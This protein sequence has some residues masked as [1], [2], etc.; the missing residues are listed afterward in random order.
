[1]ESD[2][3][4]AFDARVAPHLEDIRRYL[5]RRTQSLGPGVADGDDLLIEVLATA[6]RRLD[7]LPEGAEL[8]WL[9][10]VAR[11]T[12]A[13]ARRRQQTQHRLVDRLPLPHHAP[14]AE[15]VVVADLA[16]A[17]ALAGLTVS[18]RE[19][20]ELAAFEGLSPAEIAV[21]LSISVNAASIRLHRA[22]Q[23]LRELL[24]AKDPDSAR[25]R[26]SGGAQR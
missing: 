10:G 21:A 19:V 6:W 24:E 5:F 20:L 16:L 18:Q 8:P 22:K 1:M 7:D 11:R 26:D 3:A 4:A 25:H 9:L 23:Q 2:R 13:N 15:Q 12:L 14:A 17:E